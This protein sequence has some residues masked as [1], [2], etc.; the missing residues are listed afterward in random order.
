MI[1]AE[2]R[3][4]RRDDWTLA[5]STDE[6]KGLHRK[7]ASGALPKAPRPVEGLTSQ[8]RSTYSSLPLEMITVRVF[9][10]RVASMIMP[11]S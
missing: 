2:A 10:E 7:G 5:E 4:T 3:T 6:A 1:L 8:N 9:P 11:V